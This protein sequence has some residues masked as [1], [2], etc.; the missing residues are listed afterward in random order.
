MR[1][2]GGCCAP[3]PLSRPLFQLIPVKNPAKTTL[4][5]PPSYSYV[6]NGDLKDSGAEHIHEEGEG[7]TEQSVQQGQA[8]QQQGRLPVQGH[9][10]AR[11]HQFI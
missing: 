1:V 7:D 10:S 3:P 2:G 4:Y 6:K 8:L 9:V 5:W 11:T